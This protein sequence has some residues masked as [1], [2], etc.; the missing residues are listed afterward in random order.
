MNSKK[1]LDWFPLDTHLDEKF[2]LIEAEFGPTGFAVVVKLLQRIYGGNGYYCE[3]TKEVALLFSRACGVGSNAVSEMIKAAL[4]RGLFD[5]NLFEKYHVLTSRGI[6][7]RYL[8]AAARRKELSIRE[9]LRLVPLPCKK[10]QNVDILSENVDILP[11]SRGDK[12]RVDKIREEDRTEEERN[13]ASDADSDDPFPSAT[14]RPIDLD[15]MMAR[16]L[17]SVKRLGPS[18]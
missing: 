13:R 2:E 3:W 12:S 15:G 10:E 9:E 7:K 11:Q 4:R 18:P 5:K 6:Q 14:E 17:E 16:Y 1:G 8:D